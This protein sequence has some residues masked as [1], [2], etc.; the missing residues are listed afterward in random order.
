MGRIEAVRTAAAVDRRMAERNMVDSVYGRCG[1]V[2]RDELTQLGEGGMRAWVG[3]RAETGEF[4]L[5][6]R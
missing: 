6:S 4:E 5:R 1:R 2:N 3:G